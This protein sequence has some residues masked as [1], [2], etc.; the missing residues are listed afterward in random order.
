MSKDRRLALRAGRAGLVGQRDNWGTWQASLPSATWF[1]S[2]FLLLSP[3]RASAQMT[4]VLT[5]HNDSMRTG[6]ALN[7]QILSPANV[8][9]NHFGLLWVLPVDGN[10]DAQPLYAAGV[11]VPG[12]GEHNLLVVA[13]ENDSV[14]AFDADSTNL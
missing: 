1:V 3:L 9:T 4:D 2:F 13:T 5:F 12:L 7:E 6:Q 14:Y 8:S 11:T 10:V